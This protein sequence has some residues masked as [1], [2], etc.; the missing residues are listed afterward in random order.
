LGRFKVLAARAAWRLGCSTGDNAIAFW[1]DSLRTESPYRTAGALV[2]YFDARGGQVTVEYE[3][4]D[5]LYKASAE[6]CRHLANRYSSV[7]FQA[8]LPASEDITSSPH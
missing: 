7:G 8:S 5:E 2:T 1:L 6:Y 3:I 4:I